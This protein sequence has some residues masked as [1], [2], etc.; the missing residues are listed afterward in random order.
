MQVEEAAAEQDRPCNLIPQSDYW[1][2]VIVN[3][4]LNLKCILQDSETAHS[5]IKHMPQVHTGQ[6]AAHHTVT[7]VRHYLCYMQ[8]LRFCPVPSGGAV[9]G[10]ETKI[11]LSLSNSEML[12]GQNGPQCNIGS[13]VDWRRWTAT[14][15]GQSDPLHAASPAVEHHAQNPKVVHIPWRSNQLA[16]YFEQWA[17]T[18]SLYSL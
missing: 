2:W 13:S 12:Y 18:R 1:K 15:S 17:P 14:E 10:Q 11:P 3:V 7:S 9:Q 16:T 8:W 5:C 4:L 6:A